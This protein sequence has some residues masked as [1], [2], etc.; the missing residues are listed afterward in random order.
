MPWKITTPDGREYDCETFMS[1]AIKPPRVRL[2]AGRLGAY[3]ALP[4][5]REFTVEWVDDDA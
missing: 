4:N 2:D 3:R 1:S 5:A